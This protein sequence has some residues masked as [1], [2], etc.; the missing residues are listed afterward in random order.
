M[1]SFGRKGQTAELDAPESLPAPT[2]PTAPVAAPLAAFPRVN[3]IPDE[4]AREVKV[5]RSKV[6][7]GGAVV[8][9]LAAVGALYLMAAGQ[10]SAAQEQLDSATARSAALAAEAT[11]YADVP[12]VQADLAGAQQQQFLALG[13]EVRWSTILNNMAL[14]IPAGASLSSLKGTITGGPSTS[15]GAA[16]ANTVPSV[17]SIIGNAGIGTLSYEG[18][19]LDQPRVASFLEAVSRNTGVL[20]P[21]ASQITA[22]D[23]GGPSVSTAGVGAANVPAQKGVSF[24]ATATIT[25]KALSHRYDLKAG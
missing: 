16:G 8:A 6:I 24:T 13:G 3:L 10:V 5:R 1:V 17:V 15:S 23:T 20:D 2:T 22:K 18:E 25:T 7:A 11:K 14:T 21:F 12:K 4:I 19:A 9:S